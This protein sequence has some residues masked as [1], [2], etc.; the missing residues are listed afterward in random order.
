MFWLLSVDIF[1]TSLF[2][3][4]TNNSVYNSTLN[5]QNTLIWTWIFAPVGPS[6]GLRRALVGVAANMNPVNLEAQGV[7]WP[8]SSRNC[9]HSTF[10]WCFQTDR[11]LIKYG[12]R[13]SLTSMVRQARSRIISFV[14][15]G[16]FDNLLNYTPSNGKLPN[17]T[18]YLS[19]I[20]CRDMIR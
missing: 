5:S 9:P 7:I 3:W 8:S 2:S 19:V 1:E 16:H 11:I 17:Y 14:V 12:W 15:W 13:K 10:I 20:W 6:Q 4:V 18:S